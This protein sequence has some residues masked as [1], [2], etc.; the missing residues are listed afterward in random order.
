MDLLE[1]SRSDVIAAASLLLAVII[2]SVGLYRYFRSGPVLQIEIIPP[3]KNRRNEKDSDRII[4]VAVT[5]RGNRPANIW[6]LQLRTV[7]SRF[8]FSKSVLNEAIF[9]DA[10]PWKP[11]AKVEPHD[12]KTYDL[13]FFGGW[14]KVSAPSE[15]IEVAVFVRGRE[16]PFV[17]YSWG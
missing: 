14:T 13:Q 7:E 1:W 15:K 5:K 10:T 12:S 16:K 6:R 17:A 3:R 4:T 2:A 9:D 8:V 11:T